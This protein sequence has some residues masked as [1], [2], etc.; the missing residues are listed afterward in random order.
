MS[1]Q[2]E[3]SAP[4]PGDLTTLHL[5]LG[6]PPVCDADA[7][8]VADANPVVPA[9]SGAERRR[10]MRHHQHLVATCRVIDAATG[11]PGRTVFRGEVCDLSEEGAGLRVDNRGGVLDPDS[12]G[13]LAIRL[14]VPSPTGGV[15][16]ALDGIVR[17]CRPERAGRTRIIRV[18]VAFCLPDAPETRV[19]TDIVA[20]GKG[21]QQFLWNLWETY[22]QSR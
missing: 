17:W 13:G 19:I 4:T 20:Q 1:T 12:A 5:P 8:A 11:E 15:P 10:D 2:S 14:E 16:I 18:G 9:K 7:P 22:T 3:L 21:D 6:A